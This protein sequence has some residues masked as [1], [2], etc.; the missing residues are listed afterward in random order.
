MTKKNSP[1]GINAVLKHLAA[2]LLATAFLHSYEEPYLQNIQ[3]LTSVEQGFEKAG[4]AYFSPDGKKVSFQGVPLGE[5]DYQIFTLDLESG[6]FTQISQ[7]MGACT[8]SYFHPKEK[9][10]LFAASPIK[11]SKA[12][13]GSYKWDLTPYMNLYEA[14]LDGENLVQ[15][16]F[17]ESYHAECAYSPDGNEIVFASNVDGHMN[18]YVMNRDGGNIRQLTHTKNCYNGGPFFSPDG[19]KIVYRSDEV[20]P[21]LLQIYVIDRN[22]EIKLLLTNNK[23]VNWAPFWHPSGNAVLYT[24][25]FHGH[26]NYQIYFLNLLSKEQFR[27]THSR[28][29]DGLPSLNQEGT[30]LLWTSKR[31]NDKSSQVFI[32]D[33]C[34]PKEWLSGESVKGAEYD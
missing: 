13:P 16:T 14:D 24:T 19:T 15:L 25:S 21:G 17:G 23:D 9:R 6:I 32:A 2:L 4:E 8:C 12:P 1:Q 26:H 29:F 22:G 31:G 20:T 3:Q 28:T 30:R 18:L 7:G 34:I 33:F 27:V 5:E 11:T 10:I